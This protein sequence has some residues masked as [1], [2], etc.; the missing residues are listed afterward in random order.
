MSRR[1]L[2]FDV[3]ETLLDVKALRPRFAEV[4]GD[5]SLLAPWFGLLLRNSLVATATETYRPF[6]V[7][8]T[9]ALVVTAHRAGIDL[10]WD[11]A[12]T[13]VAGMTELPP[14]PE[15][16]AALRRLADSDYMVVA[17]TNSSPSMVEAQITNA[18]IR[19]HF[20]ELFSVEPAGVFKPDPRPYRLVG[21]A[22]SVPM[23]RMRMIAAHDWDVTGAMRAGMLGAFVARPGQ[24]VS[25]L[26]E[27]P[28]IVGAD[29]GEIA[30]QLLAG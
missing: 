26:G 21:K 16:P 14:H 5:E 24:A 11:E 30:D 6:D 15:V 29:L 7:Q 22:L 2:V 1:V 27:T 28:D 9:D 20:D 25:A 18:G 23:G 3:N 8:G 12:A 19:E 17:L 10:P 4:V 13:V